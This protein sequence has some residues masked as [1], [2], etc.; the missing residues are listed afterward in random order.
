MF[1]AFLGPAFLPQIVLSQQ[2][3]A[4]EPGSP[5]VYHS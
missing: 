4:S 3:T 5:C 2:D 1:I